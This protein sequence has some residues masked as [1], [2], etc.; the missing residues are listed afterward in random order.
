MKIIKTPNDIKRYEL[1]KEKANIGCHVCP[2]CGNTNI[3]DLFT[4]IVSPSD[5]DIVKMTF[6]C[7]K[8]RFFT[9]KTGHI[10][11]YECKKCGTEWE[12]EM[13]E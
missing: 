11:K 5:T 2:T 7:T 13:Y 12:S 4:H 1:S 3:V 6:G 9:Y 8:E 10:D